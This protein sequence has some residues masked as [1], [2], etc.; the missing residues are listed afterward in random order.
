MTDKTFARYAD[1]LRRDFTAFSHRSFRAL[2]GDVPYL[3]NWHLDVMAAKLEDVRT[4]RTRRLV[5]SLPPRHL[6]S[7]MASIAWVAFMLGHDPSRQIICASYAQ[8][9]ADKLARDCRAEMQAP[10]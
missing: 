1:I 4:G 3:G 8:D 6:K 5:I 10:F 2:N 7:H 9:L